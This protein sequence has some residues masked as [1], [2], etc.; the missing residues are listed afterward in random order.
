[1]KIASLLSK[2]K[3]I[4]EDLSKVQ[5]GSRGH[6][7]RHH[8]SSNNRVY[9]SALHVQPHAHITHQTPG[10]MTSHPGQN[11]SKMIPWPPPRTNTMSS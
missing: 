11:T 6:Q 2:C 10:P 3:Q 1:M 9:L 5:A 8:L 4:Y 7:F